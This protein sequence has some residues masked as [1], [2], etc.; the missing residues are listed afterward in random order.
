MLQE[1]S[2]R[3]AAST[4]AMSVSPSY[5]L[6]LTA[7]L[8]RLSL[9]EKLKASTLGVHVDPHH[10]LRRLP[11]MRSLFFPSA[12]HPSNPLFHPS[13][14]PTPATKAMTPTPESPCPPFAPIPPFLAPLAPRISTTS[15][16]EV[17]VHISEAFQVI[18]SPHIGGLDA[19]SPV[20]SWQGEPRST[21]SLHGSR[22]RWRTTPTQRFPSVPLCKRS[23]QQRT[24]FSTLAT[25]R[26]LSH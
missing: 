9:P 21:R 12:L 22:I 1:S 5:W 25:H 13:P 6:V 10:P 4:I 2:N 14:L 16:D 11:Q 24:T 7:Y 20:L 23:L 26:Y 19:S 17:E 3:L 8:G 18:G 15:S